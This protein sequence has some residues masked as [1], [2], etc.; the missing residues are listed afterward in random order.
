[1]YTLHDNQKAD[2][3]S[4]IENGNTTVAQ[5]TLDQR[6]QMYPL[7]THLYNLKA[8]SGQHLTNT[9]GVTYTFTQHVP[10]PRINLFRG[11]ESY[12][13]F[14][15]QDTFL[16]LQRKVNQ[17]GMLY[18]EVSLLSGNQKYLPKYFYAGN[19]TLHDLTRKDEGLRI[20][21]LQDENID[22]YCFYDVP[23]T[24]ATTQDFSITLT[25][26]ASLSGKD[27]YATTSYS[28]EYYLT[29]LDTGFQFCQEVAKFI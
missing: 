6:N 14:P 10:L 23:S 17:T 7:T 28:P 22:I 12:Y 1:M 15:K 5:K 8:G 11:E 16:E 2:L 20:T 19:N 27:V 21:E 4:A 13:S 3:K 24:L 25:S 9:S 26:G 29:S 18:N